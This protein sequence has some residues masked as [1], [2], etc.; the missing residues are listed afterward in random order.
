MAVRKIVVADIPELVAAVLQIHVGLPKDALLW[1]RGAGCRTYELLPRLMRDNQPAD[2]VFA[3]EARLL[4]RFRQRSMPYWPAGY[5]QNDW[6]HLFAMQHFGIPTRLL[7]WTEN[8][9]VAAHF[10]L[11]E[12][13]GSHD[14]HTESC[15]PAIYCLDPVAWNRKS[16]PLSEYGDDI[17]VL[18]TV[19]Q[20][21]EAYRPVTE[22]RRTTTPVA[23]FGSHNSNRIVAQRGTFLVWGKE[24]RSLQLFADDLGDSLLWQ[25]DLT[26]D[27]ELLLGHLRALGFSET[28]VFP[29]LP[30]LADE[31]SRLE[32]WH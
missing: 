2:K 9:F 32:G 6:E 21:A 25:I 16:P 30:S 3:R 11:A 13:V 8:V 17:H 23:I 14:S 18:T 20:E 29:E 19:D 27:R 24:T 15:T 1:F 28:M 10:A 5:P 7:D 12:R 4:T 26:G 31:L 22:R